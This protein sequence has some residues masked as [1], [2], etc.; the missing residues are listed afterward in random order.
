[1]QASTDYPEFELLASPDI[2]GVAVG[3]FALGG[4]AVGGLAYAGL[5]LGWYAIG[6]LAVGYAAVGGLAVGYFALGG[7]AFGKFV[8]SP[9]QRDLQAVE[10]FSRLWHGGPMPHDLRTLLSNC[11][12]RN[13]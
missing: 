7:A 11:S 6:G 12:D 4:V 5:A 10:F 8:V 13:R 1:M 3:G 2:G 9:I